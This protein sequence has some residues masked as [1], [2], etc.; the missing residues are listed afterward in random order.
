ME[1]YKTA[2]PDITLYMAYS[3]SKREKKEH[4]YI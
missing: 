4:T 1:A 2:H 3:R